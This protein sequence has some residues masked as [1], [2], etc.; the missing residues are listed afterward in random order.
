MILETGKWDAPAGRVFIYAKMDCST[1]PQSQKSKNDGSKLSI[2]SSTSG[3]DFGRYTGLSED[4]IAQLVAE[5]RRAEKQPNDETEFQFPLFSFQKPAI[6]FDPVK[7]TEDVLFVGNFA[8]EGRATASIGRANELYFLK[9]EDYICRD[10]VD[11]DCFCPRT[12]KQ[13]VG[14][15][16]SAV[17]EFYIR[18]LINATLRDD[19]LRTG[20]ISKRF[21]GRF[22]GGSPFRDA[23]IELSDTICESRGISDELLQAHL[24]RLD[25]IKDED[26]TAVNMYSFDIRHMNKRG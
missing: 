19:Q 13:V 8:D 20:V 17:F 24:D 2:F 14:R 26:W 4:R 23:A 12:H 5:Q 18:P 16:S 3:R 10:P 6:D 22:S 21:T 9:F 25:A 7:G 11:A 1:V 15:L